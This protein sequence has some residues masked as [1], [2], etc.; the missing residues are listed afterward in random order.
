M[1][2]KSLFVRESFSY[3]NHDVKE[4]WSLSGVVSIN[5]LKPRGTLLHHVRI[6]FV[7]RG[8]SEKKIVSIMR[9]SSSKTLS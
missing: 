3:I 8:Y 4:A 2:L 6:P 1:V 9:Y 5:P 7:L